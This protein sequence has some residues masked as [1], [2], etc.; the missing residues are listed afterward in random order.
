[1]SEICL[2]LPVPTS[3]NATR[4]IDWE[5]NMRRRNWAKLADTMI[6]ARKRGPMPT[7]DGP[8]EVIITVS[9]ADTKGD[10]D[11]FAK[12]L[13]DY[14]VRLGLVH[15]DTPKYLRRVTL[16]WGEAMDGCRMMLRPVDN[17]GN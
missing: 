9:E 10:L 14:A 13:I 8:F 1:M 5:G 7:I 4:R 2:D 16:E 3:V 6:L 15:D 17:H 12:V 11:G